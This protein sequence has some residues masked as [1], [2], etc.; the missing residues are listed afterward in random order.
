MKSTWS[1]QV[2]RAIVVLVGVVSAA[3]YGQERSST[4]TIYNDLIPFVDLK[5]VRVEIKGLGG[6]IFNVPEVVGDP[7][8]AITGLSRTQHEQLERAIRADISEAFRVDGI[9]LLQSSGTASEIQPVL[10]IQINWYR[11][12]PDAISVQVKANLM[13]PAHLLK[14][15]KEIVWASTWGNAY[16]SVSSGSDL[17]DVV[18]STTRNQVAQFIRLYARAHSN[19]PDISLPNL[20]IR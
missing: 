1:I 13:E 9:P 15:P 11:V 7:E 20:K 17:V 10:S 3:G 19:E 8:T 12:K 5:G 18:R 4:G 6:G 16:N 14:D 2:L